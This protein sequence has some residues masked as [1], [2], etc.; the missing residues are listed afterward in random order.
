MKLFNVNPKEDANMAQSKAEEEARKEASEMGIL[1]M[2]DKQS[3]AL[4]KGLLENA[5]P[6]DYEFEVVRK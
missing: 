1:E 5:V 4:I 2:A 3:E 6:D